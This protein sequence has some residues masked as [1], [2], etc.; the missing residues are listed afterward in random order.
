M[1][2][3]EKVILKESFL[4]IPAEHYRWRSLN[5]KNIDPI[6]KQPEINIPDIAIEE[7]IAG[8]P[9]FKNQILAAYDFLKKKEKIDYSKTFKSH[10]PLI[11][12]TIWAL[13]PSLNKSTQGLGDEVLRRNLIPLFEKEKPLN[14]PQKESQKQK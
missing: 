2:I 8:R 13:N 14:Q 4:E 12:E 7:K 9:S 11:R 3:S 1:N 10:I 5:Q 6:L